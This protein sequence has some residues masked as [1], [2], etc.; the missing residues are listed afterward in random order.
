MMAKMPHRNSVLLL[1]LAAAPARSLTPV[2]IQKVA[3]LVAKEAKK[4][5]PKPFYKFEPY[6]YGPF[7]SDVYSDLRDLEQQGLISVERPPSVRVRRYQL[8]PDGLERA[9][10]I[11]DGLPDQLTNFV[12]KATEWV[13]R[14]SFPALVRAIYARYPAYKKN[15]VFVE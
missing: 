12:T 9:Q 7:S 15:S 11:E 1:A 13:S 2:Q 3:F 4:F 8:T 6:D 14:L 10:A 5:A